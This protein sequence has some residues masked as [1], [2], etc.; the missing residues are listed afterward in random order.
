MNA[1]ILLALMGAASMASAQSAPA[2]AEDL[3]RLIRAGDSDGLRRAAANP[4]VVSGLG[5]TPLHYA[6]TFGSADSVRI[7]LERGAGP[8]A[9]NRAGA[10]P[11]IYGAYNF[12]KARLLVEKGADVNAHAQNGSTPLMIA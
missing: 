8:N 1:R 10:T 9:R 2:K 12:E 6:S 5:E 4:N 3:M 7:L 11:L